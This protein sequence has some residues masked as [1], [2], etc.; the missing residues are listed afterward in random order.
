MRI[1]VAYYSLTGNSRGVAQKIAQS[2]KGHEVAVEEI[3]PTVPYSLPSAYVLGGKDA[4]FKKIVELE[5]LQN[6]A[7]EFGGLVVV[8]PCWA[9][10]FTPPIRAFIAKLPQGG[11]KP[12][13]AVMMQ[14]GKGDKAVSLLAEALQEKGWNVS[15]KIFVAGKGGENEAAAC[16]QACGA[17][18]KK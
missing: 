11:G 6:D 17:F 12:A 15:A 7:S 18:A 1:L 2:L 14:D 5:P 13:V 3:I 16:G 4:M 8:S 10:T 9:W